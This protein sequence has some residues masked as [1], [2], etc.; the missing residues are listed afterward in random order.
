LYP[1][2][3]VDLLSESNTGIDYRNCGAFDVAFSD[4]HAEALRA[5]ADRQNDIGIY[6]EQFPPARVP[7]LRAGAISAQY[8]PH[9]AVVNPRDLMHALRLACAR[10]G[11]KLREFSPIRTLPLGAPFDVSVIAAGAWSGQI[12]VMMGR[13]PAYLPE[14]MPVRGHLV[15][16]EEQSGLCDAIVRHR[17]TY[18]LRRS[19]NVVIAGSST[20]QV[21][22][23]RTIDGGIAAE[24]A[25]RAGELVPKLANLSYSA[26]NG[27]R[28]G[29]SSGHPVMGRLGNS[30][31]WLAYG[32]YRN[33]IL[34]APA[35]ARA[36]AGD[37]IGG[38]AI[39]ASLQTDW[40]LPAAHPR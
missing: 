11:V 30:S 17:Q 19:G 7:G 6:S 15:A 32:H 38:Q 9:D 16:F 39:P 26:W 13:E 14:A 20:E 29:S 37:I 3:I 27:L 18:L 25:T 21:G 36:I 22:F 8:F 23:D 33:G 34:L 5:R 31:I 28:P 4:A 40:S 12:A 24:I 1:D 2:F 35:V 10:V